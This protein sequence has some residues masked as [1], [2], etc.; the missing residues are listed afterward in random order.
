MHYLF[1]LKRVTDNTL[2]KIIQVLLYIFLRDE[3]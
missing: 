2:Y 1:S 3:D